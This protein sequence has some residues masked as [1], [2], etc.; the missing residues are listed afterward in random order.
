MRA[1]TVPASVYRKNGVPRPPTTPMTARLAL[2]CRTLI[3]NVNT[4]TST[5]KPKA[6][7]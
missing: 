5:M 1:G 4:V 3:V 7:G 6:T 2:S